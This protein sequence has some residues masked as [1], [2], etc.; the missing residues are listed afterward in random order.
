MSTYTLSDH[1][2]KPSKG[3]LPDPI[4]TPKEHLSL[5]LRIVLFLRLS[6]KSQYIR[7]IIAMFKV[8]MNDRTPARETKLTAI[9]TN[10]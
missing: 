2:S 1:L 3:S 10:P 5:E 4:N 8:M 7:I 9:G 6:P